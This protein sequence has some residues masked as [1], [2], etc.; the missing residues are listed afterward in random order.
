MAIPESAPAQVTVEEILR[1]RRRRKKY[2]VM[3][4]DIK[5]IALNVEAGKK[6]DILRKTIGELA[7]VGAEFAA[8]KAQITELAEQQK[9]PEQEIKNLAQTHEGLRGVQSEPDNFKL[10]VFPKHSI[11]WNTELLRE[12]LGI[13]YESVVREDLS[14]SISIPHGYKTKKGPL[15]SEL[16]QAALIKGLVGLGLPEAELS[17]IVDPQVVPRVDETKLADLLAEGRVSLLEGAG[18]PTETWAITVEP[19]KKP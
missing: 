2:D 16:L 17:V 8:R 14:V 9:E 7:I 18:V 15:S 4:T 1:K 19:L 12:S 11:A 5:G 13:A 6:L 3:P 10:N